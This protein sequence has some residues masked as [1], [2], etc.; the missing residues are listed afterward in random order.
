MGKMK[1][2]LRMLFNKAFRFEDQE[3]LHSKI[4][5][6][7]HDNRELIEANIGLRL[8]LKKKNQEKIKVVF[9]CHRP[10][11]WSSIEPIYMALKNDEEF[12]PIIVAIPVKKEIP[13][14]GFK[15]DVYESEGA[16]EFWR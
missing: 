8:K 4:R 15:H 14:L 7:E 9:I 5:M 10:A 6:L 1:T 13:R 11:I 3:L 16:E 12:E 2:K